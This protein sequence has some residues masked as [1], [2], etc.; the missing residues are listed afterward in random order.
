MSL[1]ETL[2]IVHIIAAALV[3]GGVATLLLQGYAAMNSGCESEILSFTEKSDVLGTRLFAP[4]SV[5]LLVAGIWAASDGSWDFADP[6]IGIGFAVWIVMVLTGAIFFP[7]NS[8]N[9]R[10]AIASHG[11]VS[12][13][14]KSHVRGGAIVA[15]LVLAILVVAVWAM[16]AKP[17]L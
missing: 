8:R 14:V 13:E 9:V 4:A 7:R 5:V 10:D 3:I 12:R 6:W 16:V 2:V 11:V 15:T 17:G 1:Y